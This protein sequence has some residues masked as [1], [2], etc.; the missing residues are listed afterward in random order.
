VDIRTQE[1]YK[2][3][4]G[5]TASETIVGRWLNLNKAKVL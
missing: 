4:G 2:P 3:L 5:K 1:N